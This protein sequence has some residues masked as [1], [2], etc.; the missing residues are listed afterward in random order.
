MRRYTFHDLLTQH[1]GLKSPLDPHP[2]PDITVTTSVCA[3][4]E[5]C[6]VQSLANGVSYK[7]LFDAA[8]GLPQ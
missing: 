2:S 3:S 1:R 8:G 7:L 6:C 5:L 4:F